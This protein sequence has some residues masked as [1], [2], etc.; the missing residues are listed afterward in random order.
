MSLC[1]KYIPDRLRARFARVVAIAFALVAALPISASAQS[2]YV[3]QS[4]GSI[5]RVENGGTVTP[6][7][8]TSGAEGMAVTSAGNLLVADSSDNV[9][10][11]FTPSGTRTV[12]AA[13][14]NAPSDIAIDANGNVFVANTGA[15]EVV[16]LSPD[17]SSSSVFASALGSPEALTFAPNGDLFVAEASSNRV[18]RFDATDATHARLDFATGVTGPVTLTFNSDA[19]QLLVGRGTGIILVYDRVSG[20]RQANF[21]KTFGTTADLTFDTGGVFYVLDAQNRKIVRNSADGKTSSTV[22]TFTT[23]L[24]GFVL[25][26]ATVAASKADS[27][28]DHGDGKAREG[29]AI[30]YQVTITN[31]GGDVAANAQLND[32]APTNTTDVAGSMRMSPIAI[33]D[34][35]L[36]TMDTALTVP[37][38]GVLANDKGIPAPTAVAIANGATT[39]GGTV[40]LNAD[41]SFTYK[42]AAGYID[43][44]SFT[45]TATNGQSPNDTA[46]VRI[47]VNVA[48]TDITISNASVA[49][50]QPAGTEIGSFQ[51]SDLNSADA[52][53]FSLVSGA[54]D[55]DNASFTIDQD[56]KLRTAA[57]FDYETKKSYAIRVRADDQ[58]GGTF[59]KPFT[60]AVTDVNEAPTAVADSYSTNEDTPLSVAAPGVLA[61]DTDPEAGAMTAALVSGPTNALSFTLNSD[62]SFSYTPNPN[63][64]GPDSFTYKPNDGTYDGN[65]VTVSI[66]VIAVNDAPV[67]AAD[68]YSTDEDTALSVPA[69]GVL[70]NDSDIDSS[71][72]TA[73][74]ATN[75]SHAL[76]FTL[77]SDGSFSYTPAADYNGPDSFSYKAN[78]GSLDSNTVTVSINVTAVNDAPTATNQSGLTTNEDTPLA[79]TLAGTDP[80]GD[81]LTFT[82]GNPTNGTITGSGSSITYTPAQDYFGPDSFTFTVDDSHGG[83][84]QGQ[85]NLTVTSVND[86][87]V[88]DLDD[89]TG[90]HDAVANF[91][92]V[93][94]HDATGAVLVAPRAAVTDVDNPNIESGTITL[95]NRPDGAAESLSINTSGTTIAASSYNSS[96]GVL[97]LSGTATKA[98]YRQVLRTVSYNNTA[99]GPNAANRSVTF[100]VKDGD[101][102]SAVATAVV[103]V[104]PIDAPPVVDLN[105]AALGFD[106]SVSFIED[107]GA[108]AIAPAADVTDSDNSDLASA[109]LKLTNRPDGAFESLSVNLASSP[110]I[111]GGGYDSSTG[112]LTL[113]GGA[114]A[115]VAEFQAAIRSVKYDNSSNTPDTATRS[116]TVTVND[117]QVDSNFATASVSVAATDDAPVA[118]NDTATVTE[119]DP[120]TAIN[121][122]ANDTDVDAGP[123]S[124]ASFTAPAHG[125]V[126]ITGGGTGLT[127]QPNANY[128]NDGGAADAF[129]YT[130]TPGG[131]S[132]AVAITVTC[133]ND[134][135]SFTKGADQTVLEDA[136]TQT[137]NGWAT[138][139][140]AGP[141]ESGQTLTFLVSND[142]NA[143]FSTQPAISSNGVL[144][145]KPAA[146]ANGS[147]IVTVKL[148]DNGGGNDTS[149]AQ[150]F[151]INV[152]AVNDAPSF[153]KGADQTVLEDSGGQSVTGWATNISSGPADEASQTLTAFTS[154][155]NAAL[156]SSAPS[157]NVVTGD[158]AYTPAAN[159]FGS[160]TCTVHVQDN[161]GTAN[162]GVND[163]GNQTFTITITGVN[164]A[165][166]FTPGANVTVNEDS[167]AYSATWATA[168]SAGPNESSQTVSF[169]VT[170]N[171]NSL[172]TV[173]AG[174]PAIASNGTLTFTPAANAYGS[175][176]VTVAASDNGGTANGGDSTADDVTFTITVNPVNDPPVAGTDSFDTLGNT[177]L[178][179]DL[180]AGTTPSVNV[181]TSSTHGVLSNDSDPV[182][183]NPIAVTGIVGCADTTAPFDCTVSGQH[184]VMQADGKFSYTPAPGAT[185]G[186][187]QYVITDDPTLTGGSPASATGTV[188]ITVTDMIWYVNGS[189]GAGGNGTS[190]SP[191]NSFASLNGAGGAGDSDS[192][193]NYIFVHNSTV[194]GSLELEAGQHLYGEGYGL[195]LPYNLNG[196]GSPTVLVAAGTKPTVSSAS[197]TIKVTTAFPAEIR[198]LTIN[199]TAGN[200]IDVTTAA[201]YSGAT[202]LTIAGNTFGGVTAGTIDVNANAG[203]TGTRAISIQN[204][205][206]TG[207]HTG[208]G[209][210]VA[211]SAGTLTLDISGNSIVATGNG[212]NINGA[213]GGSTIITGFAGNTISGNTGGTGIS[214]TSATFDADTGTPAFQT[215]NGGSTNVGATGSG[216]GVGASGLVLTNCSGN[217]NFTDLNIYAD[218][219]TA[220]F[221]SGTAAYTGS[222]GLRVSTNPIVATFNAVGGAALDV[223]QVQLDLQGI[224]VSS[225]NSTGFGFN[226]SNTDGSTVTT[227]TSSSI[228]SLASATGTAFRIDSSTGTYS[229]GGTISTTQGKGVELTNNTGATI[230][231]TGALTISSGTSAAFTA[232]GGG[233]VTATQNNTSIVN[234]LTTTT[235]TALNVANTTIGA[236]GLTFRSISAGTAVGSAGDGIILDT[237]GASGRLIVVG[238]GTAGSGGTIQHKT[239]AD[240][241]RANGI[242]IYLNSTLNPSFDRMQLNDFDNFG[243]RGFNVN[244]FSLTNSVVNGANG[245]LTTPASGSVDTY[246]EGAIYFGNNGGASADTDGGSGTFTF[247]SDTISGGRGRNLS[248]VDSGNTGGDLHIN[249]TSVAFGLTQN[250]TGTHSLAVEARTSGTTTHTTIQTNTFAGQAGDAINLTGQSGTTIHG[251][252]GGATVALGNTITNT[253]AQNIVGGNSMFFQTAGDM[254]ADI[255]N[256]T[257]RDANGSGVTFFKGSGTSANTVQ[258]TFANNTI[259]ASGV[260]DS[261]SKSGNGIYLS[262]GGAGTF[263]LDFE[264]NIVQQWHG[265]FGLSAD[266]TGGSYAVNLTLLGNTFRQVTA[267]PSAFGGLGLT[268]GS[269]SSGD[270]TNVFCK[271]TGNDFGSSGTGAN[272]DILVGASGS[273]VATHTFTFSGATAAD[274]AS[275][276]AIGTFLKNSNN[277]NGASATTTATA[278]TD[279]PVTV[280]AF[281]NSAANPPLPTAPTPL[282]FAAGGVE[283]AKAARSVSVPS[284]IARD[285]ASPS[286][287]AVTQVSRNDSTGTVTA[288]EL[289]LLVASARAR[290][291]ATGLTSEQLATLHALHFEVSDLPNRRL[292]E[293][294]A[295]VIR[296]SSGGAGNG[297]FIASD[298]AEFASE[299]S[300]RY[301]VPASPAAG[302]VDLLTTMMHEM[303]HALGLPDSYDEK[304]RDDVMYGYLTTGERRSPRAGEAAGV[305][306]R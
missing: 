229:Y 254:I 208:N 45:Y 285:I 158:L 247:T 78:D 101:V 29:D 154:C 141:N 174:Q 259:G 237:T 257:M 119:D 74:L 59:E 211:T 292:G 49:E 256:N 148:Q 73:V 298:D 294:D 159:A 123:K 212:I 160:S 143:L 277:L 276:A 22:A 227:S 184:I 66:T 287:Q 282:M 76:S 33:D 7:G 9:V 135:P 32:P 39:A 109:T 226:L 111:T 127:Y 147:A 27:F 132:A 5:V 31:S 25:R 69:P 190:A 185:S 295:N 43:G 55:D 64:N 144:T 77:N 236:S 103:A 161:G 70:G 263:T 188:N 179:V 304:D 270:T 40:T 167:G 56:A 124:I 297:W 128:C 255:R 283:A 19:S 251:I 87:P 42:P 170:N 293:A 268:N 151:N 163:S 34:N 288:T 52:Q 216:N 280:S 177:E 181:T 48:P 100:T 150:T 269:P 291:E 81:T 305:P 20:V 244:G 219:G 105:G 67:A 2:F 238:T 296:V 249:V 110:H 17:G 165:P 221:A 63:Y 168:V 173:G 133:V 213:V 37:A 262:A 180:A 108:V 58:H 234:T 21:V 75:P 206:W 41:G 232:T 267:Q 210:D 15:G 23:T 246:G 89:T 50:N 205:T 118:V 278:Y 26:P 84:S 302:R 28:P 106:N 80:D 240:F 85:I 241:N 54:G 30:N 189:A 195:S 207:T 88:L 248:V 90:G 35:Y 243:I 130:L 44:D 126:V 289:D 38:P 46:I 279:A 96:T 202:T 182:E 134:P 36:A 152:T 169:G 260:L 79:I 107:A 115:T 191:F 265:N 116:I 300:R 199:S 299:T 121:V 201:A 102:D 83:T 16:K 175:A 112:V 91:S 225:S 306:Q 209:I 198:G 94:A 281:K 242:G 301:T 200:A 204:N 215:V 53:R 223:T 72:L 47:D 139:I 218:N 155:T 65:T 186:T 3:A 217:I 10:Y 146:D 60:I 231:F 114:G 12:F 8:S 140:S 1:A 137:I 239:G 284:V 99:V 138:A 224:S 82:H 104:V 62:G 197:D 220:F 61:N 117:G 176:T 145:Y 157:V 113:T 92:E 271:I 57:A 252:V 228:G 24:T 13:G 235:G 125:A 156:F 68:S 6:F 261:G 178:R 131:S 11:Q 272:D 183:G 18:S 164:D 264:N 214:I 93:P 149:A 120:A 196:N 193:N 250:V 187:F 14:L 194:S 142:N 253:H 172:F 290:W 203:T 136:A 171:N 97:T 71:V 162:G 129:T 273:A 286:A 274:V 230:S 266:N 233:T 275:L 166:T 122:L 95:T 222:A 303:G 153:T 86:A 258:C 4:N 192:A 98:D 245:N 51:A